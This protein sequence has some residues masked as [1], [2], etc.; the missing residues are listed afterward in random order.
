MD[1]TSQLR[2]SIIAQSLPSPSNSFLSGLVSSRTPPP[3]TASLLATARA[4]LLAC[5]LSNSASVLDAS[6]PALP[7]DIDNVRAEDSKLPR[8]THLQVVDIENLS[9]SRWEQSEELEVIERGERRRGREVIRVTAEEG[10]GDFT[11]PS[12]QG[13]RNGSSGAAATTTPA[14]GRNATHRLVLQD[15]KGRRVYAVELKR[16]DQIG[17]GKTSMGEKLLLK[18]GTAIARGTVLLTPDRCV[19][20]G[21]RVDSW[22]DAWAK[23]RLERLKQSVGADRP[24]S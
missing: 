14:A 22:H 20:L 24:Q 9:L 2:A 7:A 1:I 13:G 5:D 6:L 17:V 12:Q 23:G 10:N 4:R 16:I 8:D 18:A 3:P 19:M 11:A 15:C 21:G